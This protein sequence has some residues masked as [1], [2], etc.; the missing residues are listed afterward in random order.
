[1]R[2]RFSVI[3]A[4]A[5]FVA[6]P[7]LLAADHKMPVAKAASTYPS[8]DSHPAE[9]VVVAAVPYDT[10]EQEK[11]F[12]AHYLENDFMPI[13][14]VVTNNSDH[15]LS[16]DQ[17]R[18]DFLSAAGDRIPAAQPEDVERR[19]THITGAGKVIPLPE[20]LP[21][22]HSKPKSPDKKIEADFN[23]FEYSA[24]TVPPHSTRAGFLFYDME[25]LGNTPLK[26]A[27]LVMRDVR[28]T[29]GQELFYFQIPLDK[30]L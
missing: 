15:P 16:L 24:I 12:R 4:L 7:C 18:I 14:V 20:P 26:G 5:L 27:S 6:T 9:R 17:A 8:Y 1:M 28:T 13:Y 3:L 21:P 19:M 10:K 11:I 22:M 29:S 23:Q 30:Y 2:P 25:G